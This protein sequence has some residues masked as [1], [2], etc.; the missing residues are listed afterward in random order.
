MEPGFSMPTG[1]EVGRGR[2]GSSS[3]SL[4]RLRTGEKNA[5]RSGHV[6]RHLVELEVGPELPAPFLGLSFVNQMALQ[7]EPF[8]VPIF[9]LIRSSLK[10]GRARNIRQG[11]LM[12]T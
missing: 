3:V 11:T 1:H 2:K 9:A 10:G 4:I 12:L 8:L 7:D 6:P 5:K